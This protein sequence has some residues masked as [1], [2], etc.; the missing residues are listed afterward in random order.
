MK[1]HVEEKLQIPLGGYLG[2]FLLPAKSLWP[3]SSA[4]ADI[5][6]LFL[7]QLP[8]YRDARPEVN[9]CTEMDDTQIGLN[10][11]GSMTVD[12]NLCRS[13]R[14]RNTKIMKNNSL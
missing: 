1:K 5:N 11:V 14:A 2:E 4:I 3:L 13:L 10:L 12:R 6:F 8:L 9:L 7:P